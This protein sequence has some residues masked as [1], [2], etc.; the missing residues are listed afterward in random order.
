MAK[1][2]TRYIESERDYERRLLREGWYKNRPIEQAE[3]ARI[4]AGIYD[5]PKEPK[6][7]FWKNLFFPKY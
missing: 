6:T 2:P 7:P 3:Q 4:V 1:P 5:E